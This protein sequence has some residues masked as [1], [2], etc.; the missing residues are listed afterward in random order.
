[1]RT[2]GW[3]AALRRLPGLGRQGPVP[4]RTMSALEADG[5]GL[6]LENGLNACSEQAIGDQSVNLDWRGL[7]QI[8]VGDCFQGLSFERDFLYVC[9]VEGTPLCRKSG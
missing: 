8:K 4:R 5:K 7:I 3:D 9:L 6:L 2:L 1:M